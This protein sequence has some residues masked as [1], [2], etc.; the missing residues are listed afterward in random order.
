MPKLPSATLQADANIV[1]REK[2]YAMP[3]YVV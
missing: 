1:I 3:L 2:L